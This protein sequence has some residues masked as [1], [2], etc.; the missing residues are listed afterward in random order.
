MH[1][2]YNSETDDLTDAQRSF[3]ASILP[4]LVNGSADDNDERALTRRQ[5]LSLAIAS[6]IVA[7]WNDGN[8]AGAAEVS[9][10]GI[11]YR[12]LGKTGVKVS[13]LG[14]GGFHVGTQQSPAESEKIIRAAID[15]GI[16]FMDNCWDYNNGESEKRMGN[17]LRNGYRD[18][19]FLM[20]K[21]DG[22]DSKTAGKQ[23]DESLSRLQTDHIDLVQFHEIIRMNDSDNIFRKGGA[24]EAAVKAKEQGKIKYIGFTGHKHPEIHL[25]MLDVA[26]ANGF[27]FD[28]VQMPLNVMDAHFDSFEKRVLPVLVKNGI[29]VLGMKPLGGGVILK[30]KTV[31]P[32]ECLQYALSLPTSVVITGCDSMEILDQALRTVREFKPLSAAERKALL[33]KTASVA[34]NGQLELYKT[35]KHFDGTV[36][37]PEWLG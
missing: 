15:N 16:N 24:I 29:A 12:A 32:V 5:F 3:L 11:P 26:R 33:G 17:A 34:A 23:I 14:L 1:E 6:C 20:T 25:K 31:T 35:S 9:H 22:R 30:S 13:A 28:S 21:I 36:K 37:H 2:P 4:T 19:V 27:S 7:Q 10:N 18:K 8:W